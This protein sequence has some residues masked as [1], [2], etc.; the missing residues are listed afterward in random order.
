MKHNY[1]ELIVWQQSRILVKEVY[2]VTKDFPREEMF[3]LTSQ[4]RRAAVSVPSNIAEGFGRG[5]N[6][7]IKQF[8]NIAHGSLLEVDTQIILS[9]D[10]EY[11]NN[12]Q[13][14]TFSQKIS[15][16]SKMIDALSLK[17]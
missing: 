16:I 6:A 4:I 9:F 14:E 11:I 3:G 15:S 5:T 8:L 7:Q 2:H 12:N 1:K 13:L 17:F 10:L